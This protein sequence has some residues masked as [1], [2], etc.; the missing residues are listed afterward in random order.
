M[1]FGG[2]YWLAALVAGS[3]Y[4]PVAVLATLGGG[5]G[6]AGASGGVEQQGPAAGGGGGGG[7]ASGEGQ[8]PQHDGQYHY[9]EY[10]LELRGFQ[11]EE[12]EDFGPL[13]IAGASLAF[14][15]THAEGPGGARGDRRAHALG[16]SRL[17]SLSPP[18]ALSSASPLAAGEAAAAAAK[19]EEESSEGSQGSEPWRAALW[20]GGALAH[21]LWRSPA[22]FHT[23]H[24]VL[25]HGHWV[26]RGKGSESPAW[27]RAAWG[28]ADDDEDEEEEEE[29]AP[30]VL[31]HAAVVAVPPGCSGSNTTPVGL[32]QAALR[33]WAMPPA[34]EQGQGQQPSRLLEKHAAQVTLGQ[35]G[36]LL[37]DLATLPPH[38]PVVA[39]LALPLA[40]EGRRAATLSF[41]VRVARRPLG[42]GEARGFVGLLPVVVGEETG[43]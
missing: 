6:G 30:R 18:W 14:P 4:K 39:R 37:P 15:L 34:G 32:R 35:A 43:V 28:A 9:F 23:N 22:F 41:E 19:G 7:G 20:G 36:F 31:R 10:A 11:L 29:E 16:Q 24:D 12:A 25:V 42:E 27:A 13:D 38:T 40:V 5:G 21:C 26:V 33:L 2:P 3:P 8:P 1:I 17:L